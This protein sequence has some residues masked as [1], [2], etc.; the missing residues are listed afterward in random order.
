MKARS[1][2]IVDGSRLAA[3]RFLENSARVS[4]DVIAQFH[5]AHPDES[6]HRSDTIGS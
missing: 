4:V 3:M 1:L 5:H 2:S 6:V